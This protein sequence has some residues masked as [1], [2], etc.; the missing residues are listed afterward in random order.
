MI[1]ILLISIVVLF[2]L[3]VPVAIALGSSTIIALMAGG[4]RLDDIPN[5]LLGGVDS[6]I[7]MAIPFFMLTGQLMVEGGVARRL[8]NFAELLVGWLPGGLGMATIAASVEFADIS[9]SCTADTAAIGSIMIPAMKKRGYLPSFAAAVQAAGGSLGMLFPPAI[10]LII[11]ATV[12]NTSVGRLFLSSIVPGVM[13]ALSFMVV[14]FFISRKRGY[15]VE[16]FP[17]M[18]QSWAIIKDGILALF[19]PVIILGG[20]LTGI[21]TPTE[22]GVVAVIYVLLIS[23]F[24]YKSLDWKKFKRSFINAVITSSMVVFIISNATLLG[25]FLV[26]Q[27]IPQQVSLFLVNTIH[28]PYV[29]LIGLQLL[30]LIV[31]SVLETNTTIIVIVPILLPV[32]SQM[33]IDP[34]LFGILLM[35]NSAIGIILPPIGLNLYISSGIAGVSLEKAA[36]AVIPFALMIIVD[37][38]LVIFFPQLVSFLPNLFPS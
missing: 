14:I 23:I 34:Y 36:I 29:L 4:I 6:F 9:G 19:A 5:R 28:N 3:G 13:T 31:H 30:L 18:K 1:W 12:T 20:I 32:L 21:F 33:G 16:P 17:G 15:P 38:L 7:L 35:M 8:I 10:S 22:S 27:Q 11:Y 2:G 24:V 25:W 37:I 26:T